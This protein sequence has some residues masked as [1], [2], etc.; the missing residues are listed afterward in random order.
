M[1]HLENFNE[2]VKENTKRK[3]DITEEDSNNIEELLFDKMKENDL[4]PDIYNIYFELDLLKKD[5][6]NSLIYSIIKKYFNIYPQSTERYDRAKT[7]TLAMHTCMRFFEKR[8]GDVIRQY[9]LD[10]KKEFEIE[11]QKIKNYVYLPFGDEIVKVPERIGHN[12]KPIKI[13]PLEDLQTKYS[14]HKRLK[15]FA[16]KGL[17]CVSCDRVGKYLIAGKDNGGA[18]HLDIYTGDF[19]LMTIDHIKPKSKGGSY[20]IENLDPMCVFCNT[21]KSD[22]YEELDQAI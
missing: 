20:A 2:Q 22:K 13:L 9:K 8:Y 17:K 15:V 4:T 11:N 3:I 18:I 5:R 16:A 1:K 7:S 10:R 21:E 14:R 6:R 12:Y 19:E